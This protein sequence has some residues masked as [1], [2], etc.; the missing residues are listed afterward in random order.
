MN[1]RSYTQ[2]KSG[3][4]TLYESEKKTI[5]YLMGSNLAKKSAISSS[6]WI[7]L[8]NSRQS[9]KSETAEQNSVD[10]LSLSRNS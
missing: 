4:F 1:A 5:H 8:S 10:I 3:N 7:M 6:S 9:G 2:T